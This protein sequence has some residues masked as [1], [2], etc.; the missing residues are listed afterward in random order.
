MTA[1]LLDLPPGRWPE[2][3]VELGGRPFQGASAA[4][5]VFRRGILEWSDMT[6]LPA[7]LRERLAREEPLC[8]ARLVDSVGAAD[9]A[10]KVLLALPDGAAVEAVGMPG[11]QGHTLCISTQV[12]CPVRCPF[13]AS[14]LEGLERNLSAAE[15]LE[16]VLFLHHAL[17]SYGRLVVMGMGDAG[18]NLENTLTAL[19]ALLAEEGAG[20]SARRVTLS[21]V[22]PRGALERIAEWGRPVTLAL[23]LHAPDDELRRELVPGTRKRGIAE[24]LDE[25]DR[26]FAASGRE[27]TVE[28]VLLA[29]INDAPEQ[30]RRLAERLRGRRC[31]LNLIPYNAVPA[32]EYQRPA[33]EAQLRFAE[34]T[35]GAGTST[36]LRRSLGGAAEAACG[37]LRRRATGP[38][39]I[40]GAGPEAGNLVQDP[41]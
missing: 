22:A 40:G 10:H 2:R 31:H 21:T 26:L 17:G 18:F 32:L 23:S 8:R 7:S 37:Q 24:T 6:D 36:T 4:R 15:I 38:A 39:Q 20:L 13:C 28:Y 9:G 3:F 14:G 30:A 25:A 11:T 12:G 5:W 27:Y 35:R 34:I 33:L 16:Q 19:D 29:G 1:R 41:G